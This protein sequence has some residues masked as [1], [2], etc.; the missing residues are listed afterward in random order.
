MIQLTAKEK[1][2]ILKSLED[3]NLDPSKIQEY[4][5]YLEIPSLSTPILK[6]FLDFLINLDSQI[7]AFYETLSEEDWENVISPNCSVLDSNFD[8]KTKID[9]FEMHFKSFYTSLKDL[10]SQE[11]DLEN[12]TTVFNIFEPLFKIKT[13]NIQFLIFLFSKKNPKYAFGS[14][15]SKIKKSP[16]IYCPF[17]SSLLVRLK[18]DI[19]LKR[20]CLL[21]FYNHIQ[22]ITPSDSVQYL[23]LLQGFAY[24]LCFKEFSENITD[25][26]K[27]LPNFIS[28]IEELNLLGYLNKDVASRFC[29]FYNIKEPA[30]QKPKNEVFYFFPFDLPVIPGISQMIEEDYVVFS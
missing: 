12:I 9:C 6:K 10:N 7:S 8:L 24:I 18:F 4:L 5:K 14:L 13:K 19:E 26:L 22:S 20:K 28:K 27:N 1:I 25:L 17:F 2:A 30:Y 11:N 23:I 21:V 29:S 3:P 16:L 15:L